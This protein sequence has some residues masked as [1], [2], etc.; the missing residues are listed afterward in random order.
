MKARTVIIHHKSVQ[1]YQVRMK[2]I[3]DWTWL[4]FELCNELS[5]TPKV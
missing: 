2:L 5:L 4:H 3:S 1:D